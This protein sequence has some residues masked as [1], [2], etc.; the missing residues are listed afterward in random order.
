MLNFFSDDTSLFFVI[1]DSKISILEMNNN[2]A[3]INRWAFKRKMN[4][5]S[6][7]KEAST[8]SHF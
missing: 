3:K 2:L 1:H 8:G 4:F 6:D 5:H 7:A